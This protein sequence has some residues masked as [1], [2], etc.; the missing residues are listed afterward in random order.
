MNNAAVN[1]DM[2]IS[3][4]L[5]LMDIYPEVGLLDLTIILRL[6]CY[7]TSILFSMLHS[8]QQCP[9]VPNSLHLHQHMLFSGFFDSDHLTFSFYTF[10]S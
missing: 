1:I 2:Y 8:P 4:S 7:G 5:I 10:L 9:S 3:L 6:I